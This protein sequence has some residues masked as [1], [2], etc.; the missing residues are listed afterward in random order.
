MTLSAEKANRAYFRRAYRTG[1][2]GW[3]VERPA[4]LA[5]RFLRRLARE[6]PRGKLLDIG[7]GEGRHAIA[8]AKMGF[9]VTAADF[10]PL[11]IARARRFARKH[12][13]RGIAFRVADA[14][15]L[16]FPAA[17]FDVVFDYGCLHHQR[18]SDQ[19]AYRRSLLRVLKP[20]GWY[21][22]CAFSPRF[23]LFRG[24]S[25]PWH[26]AQ[27]SYRRCFTH[28]DITSLFSR[29]FEI[30]ALLDERGLGGGF[31][32]ALMRKRRET[33]S[34]ADSRRWTQI[35]QQRIMG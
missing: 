28:R 18:R 4:T 19:A 35:H 34:S 23:R 2:H 14:R 3:E 1:V 33:K 30:L 9:R 27:G 22:L 15:R 10:E 17:S 29:D 12:G 32:Q 8:A 20:R 24:C 6:V 11:A 13:A 26:I 5:V 31:L 25:R 7:C 16:P 21:V